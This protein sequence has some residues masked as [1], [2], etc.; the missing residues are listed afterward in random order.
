MLL[1]IETVNFAIVNFVIS[2]LKWAL[3]WRSFRLGYENSIVSDLCIRDNS[4][5]NV[6]LIR[7]QNHNYRLYSMAPESHVLNLYSR[8]LLRPN[9]K[10]NSLQIVTNNPL[11][12]Q[13]SQNIVNIVQFN[14][15]L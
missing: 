5:R 14:H 10:L 6:M 7:Y 8:K 15:W 2:V 4:D 13:Y 3:K 1:E 12:V 11:L 9:Y